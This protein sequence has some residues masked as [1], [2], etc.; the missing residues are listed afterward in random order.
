MIHSGGAFGGH[1]SAYIKDFESVEERWFHFN[2]TFVKEISLVDIADV[3]GQVQN[4]R[5]RRL[6]A[7]HANAYMLLYRMIPQQNDAIRLIS[8]N[9]ISDEIQE[10]VLEKTKQQ[11]TETVASI[12]RKQ[13][14]QLK[15]IHAKMVPGSDCDFTESPLAKVVLVDR[16]VDTYL[17]LKALV[18]KEF[19]GQENVDP[20]MFRLRAYNVQF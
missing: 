19:F 13:K 15:I 7:N 17:T 9:E 6:A 20:S 2:D 4:P 5:N 14:M 18:L 11:H 10:E 1:Y 12:E 8:L 16:K 3:F